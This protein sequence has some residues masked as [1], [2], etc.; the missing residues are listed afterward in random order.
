MSKWNSDAIHKITLKIVM[1]KS[2]FFG[3]ILTASNTFAFSKRVHKIKIMPDAG[4]CE[5]ITLMALQ[6]H[7]CRTKDHET[8]TR[9]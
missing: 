1:F 7:R 9:Q 8:R 6:T 3:F 2:Y 4:E 5:K